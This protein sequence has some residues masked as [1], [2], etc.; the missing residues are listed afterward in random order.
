MIRITIDI[1][2]QTG[3]SI[4]RHGT[5]KKLKSLQQCFHDYNF[6]ENIKNFHIMMEINLPQLEEFEPSTPSATDDED[7][8]SR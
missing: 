8:I 4:I 6:F 1:C 3:W 5:C 2:I 7:D